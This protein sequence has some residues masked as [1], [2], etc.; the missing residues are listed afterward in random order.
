MIPG[1]P[2]VGA[3][4]FLRGVQKDP[5]A[6]VWAPDRAVGG[7]RIHGGWLSVQLAFKTPN[8]WQFLGKVPLPFPRG[9]AIFVFL[10]VLKSLGPIESAHF[11]G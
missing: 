6:D 8:K 5:L 9:S 10:D 1:L 11:E 7:D 3:P 2:A 4:I